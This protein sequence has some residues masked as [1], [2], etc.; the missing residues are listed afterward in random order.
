MTPRAVGAEQKSRLPDLPSQRLCVTVTGP[1]A[2]ERQADGRMG[3]TEGRSPMSLFSFWATIAIWMP[4]QVSLL[5]GKHIIA[6]LSALTI[7]GCFPVSLLPLYF[8]LG[9]HLLIYPCCNP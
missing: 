2:W 1:L 9:I 6:Y 8:C 7:L 3:Q 5:S 4:K